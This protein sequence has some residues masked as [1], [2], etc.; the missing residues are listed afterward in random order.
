MRPPVITQDRRYEKQV[1]LIHNEWD[2]AT[3]R[4]ILSTKCVSQLHKHHTLDCDITRAE[5]DCG[6]C[7][8]IIQFNADGTVTSSVYS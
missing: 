3:G 6:Y 2:F 8:Y 4:Q 7:I 1:S 5:I